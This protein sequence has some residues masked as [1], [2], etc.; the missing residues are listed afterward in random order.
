ML[1]NPDNPSNLRAIDL[2]QRSR[3]R[4]RREP[5]CKINTFVVQDCNVLNFKKK[6]LKN[7]RILQKKNTREAEMRVVFSVL[8]A[9]V[10]T[11]R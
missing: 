9:N 8:F 7:M 2:D 4:M 10:P 1:P 3:I 6:Y 11:E 5:S